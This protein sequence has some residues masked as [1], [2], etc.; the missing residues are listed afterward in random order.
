VHVFSSI[1]KKLNH[2]YDEHGAGGKTEA[3]GQKRLKA[4]R[5]AKSRHSLREERGK[6][7][8]DEV[9]NVYK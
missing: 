6:C 2:G 3:Q 8:N 1:W 9:F 5:T 4:L 7:I